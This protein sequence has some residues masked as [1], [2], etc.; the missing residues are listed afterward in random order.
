MPKF[1]QADTRWQERLAAL[2]QYVQQL[3]NTPYEKRSLRDQLRSDLYHE[4]RHGDLEDESIVMCSAAVGL[5]K[6]TAVMAYSLRK[7]IAV[8]ASH[9]F[10]I[11]P[12]TNILTQTVRTLRKAVA[13][14][15][16]DP[17]EVIIEHHHRVQFSEKSM[18]QYA[19]SWAAPIVVTTAVQFFETLASANPTSLKKLHQ[20]AGSVIFIDESH[21]CLPP[22]LL[23]LSWHW[24]KCLSEFWGCQIIFSSGSMVEFWTNEYLV[25]KED[26]QS[27]P[28][29]VS[30]QLKGKI[31][32]AE[33]KRVGYQKINNP[34]TKEGLLALVRSQ[35]KKA[36]CNKPCALIILNTVQSCAYIADELARLLEQSENCLLERRQVLQLS[37]SLTPL[38]RERI[39]TE[40]QRRQKDSQWKQKP[41]YLIATSCVEAGVDL[42]F[43]LAYRERCS[44]ASF[45]QVSGRVNR[46]GKRENAILFDFELETDDEII[47][48]PGFEKS[49]EV[50]DGLWNLLK[51]EN[52]DTNMLVTKSLVK[53]LTRYPEK[54]EE[55]SCLLDQEIKCSFQKIYNKYHL[56]S[57]ENFTVITDEKIVDALNIGIKISWKEIQNHSVQLWINKF[58]KLNLKPIRNTKSDQIYSWIDTYAYNDFLGVYA[59]LI[60]TNKFIQNGGS[61]I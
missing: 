53:L 16:E 35:L 10:V 47:A 39:V 43:Q 32:S 4:C 17:Y 57:G 36:K 31:S 45:L 38:D 24:L 11:A 7:A 34:L 42:D 21:A 27:I 60:S 5:G 59:G 14:P 20:V 44:I 2:D 52:C 51:D 56:I 13:L 50:F 6:T 29:I 15:E 19:A 54:I 49:R 23:R 12:F 61:I 55:A 48:H 33:G 30:L 40:I 41:W 58:R 46:H 1:K 22:E 8:K 37:T 28:D 3:I 18:R 26:I 25:A 9:L